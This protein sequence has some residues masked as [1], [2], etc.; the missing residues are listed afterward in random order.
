MT[1]LVFATW[2]T[3]MGMPM[4][5]RFAPRGVEIGAR[6][7]L[8]PIT[9]MEEVKK[10]MYTATLLPGAFDFYLDSGAFEFWGRGEEKTVE[11]YERE[12]LDLL[13]SLL[14]IFRR[15]F[16]ISLDKIPGNKGEP[17]TQSQLER[18][19]EISI[20]NARY[21]FDK[22]IR[23]VPV[24]HQGE[25]LWVLDEYLR[26][27]DFVGLSPANDQPK[28]TRLRYMRSCWP[29]F[30]ARSE[31]GVVQPAHCFGNTSPEL[32]QA[33]PCYSADSKGWATTSDYGETSSID[34]AGNFR[35]DRYD[36]KLARA[37]KLAKVEMLSKTVEN[38]WN[39][40]EH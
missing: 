11:Q 23:V 15:V 21:M 4:Y 27:T 35:R 24:H 28:P 16:V 9:K 17:V 18:A 39:M 7:I 40:K 12:I 30:K 14:P 19:T 13:P 8:A 10:C 5:R 6:K 32:L 37:G 33:F 31:N 26:M 34:H 38:G 36:A 20:Q 22:G 25:P 29:S 2:G 1:S 3:H